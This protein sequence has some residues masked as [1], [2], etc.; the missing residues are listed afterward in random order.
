MA[1]GQAAEPP[2]IPPATPPAA[3]PPPPSSARQLSKHV[4]QPA[5]SPADLALT[6]LKGE[7]VTAWS[8][9]R[10]TVLV[11]QPPIRASINWAK[12]PQPERWR[13]HLVKQTGSKA[14]VLE[15][16]ADEGLHYAPDA[17]YLSNCPIA[18]ADWQVA[19]ARLTDGDV[20]WYSHIMVI[21]RRGRVA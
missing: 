2:A 14:D 19:G 5:P 3:K 1:I 11:Y 6:W 16:I 10:P 20:E 12:F 8:K 18:R 4:G 13:Y 17:S 7:A 21:D 15:V 9:D